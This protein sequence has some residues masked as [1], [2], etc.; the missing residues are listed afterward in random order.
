MAA[1]KI[2]SAVLVFVKQNCEHYEHREHL[3]LASAETSCS[4]EEARRH[5][6][7]KTLRARV[8]AGTYHV[9]TV[10]LARKMLACI[11]F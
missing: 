10:A 5:A 3:L 11:R 4:L 6:Y 1:H 9:D 8:E 2:P 7:I